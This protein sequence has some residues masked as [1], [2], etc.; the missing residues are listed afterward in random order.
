MHKTL[1][2]LSALTLALLANPAVASG[3]AQIPE[4]STLSLFA[5]GVLGVLVGRRAVM[6]ARR[7]ERDES[8]K[9]D[10]S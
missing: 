4:S 1:I 10:R 5:L 3:G 7:N 2:A 8:D 6:N 9:D